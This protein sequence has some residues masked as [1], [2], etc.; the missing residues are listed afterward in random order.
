LKVASKNSDKNSNGKPRQEEIDRILDKISQTGY[1]SLNKQERE[2]L[3]RASKD[4]EG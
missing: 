3:F 1:D 2:I 4:N